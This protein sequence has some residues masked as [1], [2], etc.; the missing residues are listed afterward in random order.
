MKFFKILIACTI[1]FSCNNKKNVSKI[2]LANIEYKS[3]NQ[4]FDPSVAKLT[5]IDA[6]GVIEKMIKGDSL[7]SL[8]FYS[9]D[10]I[11]NKSLYMKKGYYERNK[12]TTILYT[13][14]SF[15]DFDTVK[16]WSSNE[17]QKML[18]KKDVGLVMKKD[19][20]KISKCK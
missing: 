11:A 19:T 12:D 5:F 3:N 20:L 10:E 14:I 9:L 1:L 4:S 16:K 17:I 13:A 8:Y 18:I 6:D 2:C 15:F 7:K